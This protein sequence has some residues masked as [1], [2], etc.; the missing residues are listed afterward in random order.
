M[1]PPCT[2]GQGISTWSPGE[3]QTGKMKCQYQA[4]VVLINLSWGLH[5]LSP[6]GH[7]MSKQMGR[8]FNVGQA[9]QS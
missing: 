9:W 3:M 1:I 2:K 5:P 4:L 7:G 8:S 6:Y